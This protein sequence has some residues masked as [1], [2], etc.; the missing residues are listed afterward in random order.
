VYSIP[1]ILCMQEDGFVEKK[2][3]MQSCGA[4]FGA[5]TAAGPVPSS[6]VEG[7]SYVRACV[8]WSSIVACSS[9]KWVSFLPRFYRAAFPVSCFPISCFHYDPIC[10]RYIVQRS[11]FVV[12]IHAL[13][14]AGLSVPRE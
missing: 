6:Q 5:Y 11:V 3:I 4:M 12:W 13:N 9:C 10:S 1:S 7:I 2:N 14:N 8:L